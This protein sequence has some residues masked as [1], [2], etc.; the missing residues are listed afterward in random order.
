MNAIAD[1]FACYEAIAAVSAL[2]LRAARGAD[3]D[4]L[5]GLQDQ[6]RL[7]VEELKDADHGVRLSA[8]ER[9]RKYQ[10]IRQILADDAAVRDLATPELA[11]LSALFSGTERAAQVLQDLYGRR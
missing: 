5:A 7:L 4:S 2:M 10:L 11:R 9:A 6:Y 3:W 8:D 1:Y